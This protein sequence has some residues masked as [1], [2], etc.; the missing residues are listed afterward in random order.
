VVGSDELEENLVFFKK[1]PARDG[2]EKGRLLLLCAQIT[3]TGN[4]YSRQVAKM[5]P[6]V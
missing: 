2:M 6:S 5:S 1:S 3:G 4:E